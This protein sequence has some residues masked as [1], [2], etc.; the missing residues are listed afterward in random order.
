[1]TV[2]KTLPVINGPSPRHA[3]K[4]Y[5]IRTIDVDAEQNFGDKLNLF[6]INCL[7]TAIDVDAKRDLCGVQNLFVIK[8]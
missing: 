5:I 3:Q 7:K 4:N 1:M 8:I 2:I 6:V